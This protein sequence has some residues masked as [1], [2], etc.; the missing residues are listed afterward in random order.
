MLELKKKKKDFFKEIPVFFQMDLYS[1]TIK[2]AMNLG[3]LVTLMKFW[4]LLYFIGTLPA[5]MSIHHVRALAIEAR[6]GYGPPYRWW[7]FNPGSVGKQPVPSTADPSLHPS[8]FWAITWVV[9][10]QKGRHW[11]QRKKSLENSVMVPGETLGI[12][13]G[14]K[15][16]SMMGYM[17]HFLR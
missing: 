9:G 11:E 17:K 12:E 7:E 1:S 8:L 5:Y 6:R 13:W 3:I 14:I 10:Y 2:Q 15:M 16:Q 4:C